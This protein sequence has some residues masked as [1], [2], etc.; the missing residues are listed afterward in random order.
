MTS[1]VERRGEDYMLSSSRVSLAS[2]V[3]A[4]KEGLSPEAIRDDFPTL[5]LE[6]VYGAIAYYL[7]NQMEIDSYLSALAADFEQR[8]IERQALH[9]ELTV[10]L[11]AALETAQQ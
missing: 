11:R 7:A 6:Q 10:K 1:Y 5:R 2:V 4:W 3:Q 8:R 9:P